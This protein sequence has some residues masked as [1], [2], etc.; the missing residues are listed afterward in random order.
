[1]DLCESFSS[2][3]NAP[4][5]YNSC[6]RTGAFFDG[7]HTLQMKVCAAKM[8]IQFLTS[9]RPAIQVAGEFA[10]LEHDSD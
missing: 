9:P 5:K 3:P 8:E 7:L 6:Q 10:F 1:M 4:A 2:V